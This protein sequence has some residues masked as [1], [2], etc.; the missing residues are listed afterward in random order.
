MAETRHFAVDSA[1]HK[2]LFHG[3]P[4]GAKERATI[5]A[6]L[7]AGLA[8]EDPR[9]DAPDLLPL[10][11]LTTEHLGTE[12]DPREAMDAARGHGAVAAFTALG[13]D[14]VAMIAEFARRRYEDD[15]PD[16]LRGAVLTCL[17]A[18]LVTRHGVRIANISGPPD[19]TAAAD[20]RLV[21]N[22]DAFAPLRATSNIGFAEPPRIHPIFPIESRK[23]A[24]RAKEIL[25]DG[26]NHGQ[27]DTERAGFRTALRRHLLAADEAFRLG[28][29]VIAIT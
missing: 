28:L 16:A 20:A 18:H 11:R 12:A 23:I 4:P 10:L 21:A 8:P 13:A 26:T 15:P 1:I 3:D 29:P 22:D 27:D 14:P 2:I 7:D 6:A 25:F 5:H 24:D 17:A 9:A 19:A